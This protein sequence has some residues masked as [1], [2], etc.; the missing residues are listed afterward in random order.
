MVDLKRKS[1]VVIVCMLVVLGWYHQAQASSGDPPEPVVLF[2]YTK[3]FETSWALGQPVMV[4]N[5]DGRLHLFW[6][7]T[8]IEDTAVYYMEL[9][10]GVWSDPVDIL[11]GPNV[12][13][14]NAYV[15]VVLDSKGFLH[16]IWR[17]GSLYYSYARADSA[18][19]PHAWATP[20]EIVSGVV[21]SRL[22]I[23]ANNKLHIVYTRS[24]DVTTLSYIYCDSAAC[25]WTT[26]IGIA[27]TVQGE[28]IRYPYLW[29]S[30]AGVLHAVWGQVELPDGWPPTGVYYARSLDQGDTW[31]VPIQLG[32]EGQGNPA[33][34]GLGED[35][36][37]LVWLATQP[38]RYHTRSL[39]GGVTWAPPEEFT[40]VYGGLIVGH[41]NLSIDSAQQIHLFVEGSAMPMHSVW[42]GWQW[43]PFEPIGQGE[44]AM[45]AITQGNIIHFA[46]L[47]PAT[48]H[49]TAKMIPNAPAI[50]P[51]LR[52]E[53]EQAAKM[54]ETLFV[55]TPQPLQSEPAPSLLPSTA[56]SEFSSSSSSSSSSLHPIIPLL[57]SAGSAGLIVGIVLWIY[58]SRRKGLEG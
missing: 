10:D 5:P 17:N 53:S 33:I 15:S 46:W 37:H 57:F 41:V 13:A 51:V 14:P 25:N 9:D 38:G 32:G 39:D 44:S 54:E 11:L 1:V 29:I 31:S 40:P 23:D 12:N 47:N 55:G 58:G 18:G 42:D 20:I 50:A 35:E 6:T 4:P 16:L 27:T 7:V 19:N 22:F 45:A 8:P 2:E 36:L 30:P 52:P 34:V 48:L 24:T 21:D 43:S 26:P 49:Y 3:P 56:A 28:A